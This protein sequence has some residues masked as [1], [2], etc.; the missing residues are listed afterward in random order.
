MSS[1]TSSTEVFEFELHKKSTAPVLHWVEQVVCDARP[2]YAPFR[3]GVWSFVGYGGRI[4][5]AMVALENERT[6]KRWNLCTRRFA[7]C[8]DDGDNGYKSPSKAVSGLVRRFLTKPAYFTVSYGNK[9]AGFIAEDNSV[10]KALAEN[11]AVYLRLAIETCLCKAFQKDIMLTK[12]AIAHVHLAEIFRHVKMLQVGFTKEA[13]EAREF[14]LKTF[15][16]PKTTD[17]TEC[18]ATY[19]SVK[20]LRSKNCIVTHGVSFTGKKTNR[21]CRVTFG[22][23]DALRRPKHARGGVG[24]FNDLWAADKNVLFEVT[25]TCPIV[26]P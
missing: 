9:V 2:G 5:Y 19:K 4:V 22:E 20:R 18:V 13:A 23:S 14:L 3:V 17:E 8:I 24:A 21:T 12:K 10:W 15:G 26:Y 25:S 6:P 16:A 1:P 11:P 7:C